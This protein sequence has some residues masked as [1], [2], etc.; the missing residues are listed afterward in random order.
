MLMVLVLLAPGIAQA[1]GGK[2]KTPAA[3]TI[4]DTASKP[5]AASAMMKAP[6]Y[7]MAAS[8]LAPMPARDSGC[9]DGDGH[10]AC[11]GVSCP[12]C[13]ATLPATASD[14]AR[15]VMLCRHA[16]PARSSL[17]STR[18]NALFRPPRILV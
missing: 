9:C 8:R 15:E 14:L 4:S 13:S 6:V 11:A 17:L 12:S 7:A 1:C 2:D 3:V 10:G 18:P 5:P 16:S